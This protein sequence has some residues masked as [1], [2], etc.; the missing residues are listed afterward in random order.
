MRPDPFPGYDVLQKRHTPS[1]NEQTRGVVDRRLALVDSGAVLSEAQIAILRRIADRIVPQPIGRPPV[2]TAAILI[3]K[4]DRDEGDGY[5][6]QSLPPVRKAW[7]TGLDALEAEAQLRF[8]RSF[9]DLA[10]TEA[11]GL[12]A[13]VERGAVSHRAWEGMPPA[14]FWSW[15]L[16]PDLV[17]AYFAHPS[18]WSAMGFGG[19][20]SPRGY[21]RLGANRRDPWE[22]VEAE[23]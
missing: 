9:T 8:Q 14:I 22:A 2:N 6:H 21:V 11:D 15:R 23:R 17:S 7:R 4:I 3:E 10:D 12:L 5:R 19:P 16:L 1:W 18:A 20:A 13:A